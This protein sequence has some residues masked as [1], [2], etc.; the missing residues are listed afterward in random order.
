MKKGRLFS[1]PT[2]SI[3]LSGLGLLVLGC[4]FFTR[5]DLLRIAFERDEG[6]F[7][8]IGQQ[9][10]HGGLLYTQ[11]PDNKPP[12]LY[13]IY[14]AFVGLIG[15]MPLHIHL[16]AAIFHLAALA[17]FWN[18]LKI[19]HELPYA[20]L[21]L[22]LFS[23]YAISWQLAGFAAHA[24]QLLTLPAVAGCFFLWQSEQNSAISKTALAGL[25]FG[26]ALC[27][28]QQAF[29][30]PLGGLIF[31]GTAIREHR[32]KHTL[33]LI[34]AAALPF[35]GC[36]L[37]FA[38]QERFYDFWDN[39]FIHPAEQAIGFTE[40]IQLLTQH[41]AIVMQHWWL[42]WA[43]AFLGFGV[44]LKSGTETEKAIVWFFLLSLT[45]VFAAGPSY[46][47]YFVLCLP[48]LAIGFT[49]GIKWITTFSK[50]AG[51]IVAVVALSL[52]V[53]LKP[54]Y[55][56][57]DDESRIQ[58]M[59]YGVNPFPEMERIG[60]WLLQRK[61][62]QEEK[63]AILGSEPELYVYSRSSSP[64]RQIYH[65]RLLASTKG[66]Q[67]R[68]DEYL[69]DWNLQ[70]PHWVVLPNVSLDRFAPTAVFQTMMKDLKTNYTVVGIVDIYPDHTDYNFTPKSTDV[71]KSPSWVLV[72]EK[73]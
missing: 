35:V 68:Q 3:A 43:V 29:F 56:F 30:L 50:Y 16:G 70:Q 23:L 63:I 73:K 45:G 5:L 55:W 21:S 41:L 36:L 46:P 72:F 7:T 25:C 38:V 19:R 65:Y 27:I 24:T 39:V 9:L 60:A 34:T 71:N 66:A 10:W 42:V 64:F 17:V 28:K 44:A 59:V 61:H 51:V 47:H 8:Y 12:L 69:N 62:N 67:K 54:D 13:L 20:I 2:A 49:T 37:W 14:A 11:L 18:W 26:L 31:I 1:W 40:K 52:P 15:H 6:G 33:A 48:W 57:K 53:V 32:M 22:A 58:R 4:A